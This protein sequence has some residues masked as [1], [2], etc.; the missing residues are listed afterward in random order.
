VE[1]VAFLLEDTGERLGCLLNPESI[2][3]RRQTGIRTRHSAGGLVAGT[4]LADDRLLLTGGGRTELTLDLLFDVSLPG[5]SIASEDVRDLTGPLWRLTENTRRTD[6]FARPPLTRFVW[7][8]SWNL[9]GVV[10]AVAERL[11][12]FT[13]GGIPQ[14]SWLRMQM[15]RVVEEAMEPSGSEGRMIPY[16][17]EEVAESGP[18][19]PSQTISVHE[20]TGGGA[21]AEDGSPCASGDRLDQLAYRY[22][23]NATLWRLLAAANGIDDPLCMARGQ[24]LEMPPVSSLGAVE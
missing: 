6:G 11:E 1:R 12:Y 24:L 16:G 21:E 14:R 15:L 22:Y 19:I 18:H 10:S 3:M 17:G 2:V 5:S 8:K 23:G 9:P 20:V 4:D 7:G 13:A